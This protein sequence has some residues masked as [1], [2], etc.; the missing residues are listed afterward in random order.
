[1]HHNFNNV[2]L[3]NDDRG[4]IMTGLSGI[5]CIFG[6]SFICID[7]VVRQ[8]PGKAGWKIQDSDVFLSVSLSLSFGVMLFS[9]LYSMLPSAKSS[10]IKGGYDAKTAAWILIACFIAG[11]AG[12]QI[13]S[14]IMHRF[15][16]HNVV[17]CE[18]KHDDE[19]AHKERE[20]NHPPNGHDHHHHTKSQ[21]PRRTSTQRQ[22]SH[23]TYAR[24]QTHQRTSSHRSSCLTTLQSRIKEGV[25]KLTTGKD[26]SC[27]CDG[28]CY[29]YSDLCQSD[30]FKSPLARPHTRAAAE[31]AADAN[32]EE[33]SDDSSATAVGSNNRSHK[34]HSHHS[35]D[36][37]EL[38]EEDLD[39]PHHHHVPTNA[40]LNI[41]L[42]TSIAIALHKLPEGFITYATNHA[43]PKLGVSV[44]LAL[45][46]HNITEGFAMALP[47]YLAINNR[48][49]AMLISFALGG[50]SQPLG[51]GVAA[52]WFKAAGKRGWEPS[53]AVYGGMFAVTAGILASVA[54]QL[55]AESL[56]LTHS[57]HLC[58]IGAFAGMSI[59]GISSALTA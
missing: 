56:D 4:W 42:Q 15:I 43:N 33:P 48:L 41:G 58:M 34:T 27:T 53:E 59:L 9:A 47:L 10:L 32:I 5:A 38:D 14:R 46:I 24:P 31:G 30:C 55:F 25:S 16:P 3:S 1:M 21:H 39:H 40:F 57:K 36:S 29:G 11:V 20:H 12:I 49:K 22:N 18:H 13:I 17:D 37:H 28:P 19:E 26:P 23:R 52:L 7:I 45:F 44:F 8:F 2:G 50:L 54:L 6:A 35:E 51:A